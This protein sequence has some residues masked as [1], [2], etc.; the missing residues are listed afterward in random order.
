M[1]EYDNVLTPDDVL[2]LAAGKTGLSEVDSDSWREGLAI[3]LD[4]INTS[5]AYSESGRNRI[6]SDCVAAL[7]RRL[8]VHDY[9]QSHPEVLDAPVQRPLIV[10]G[11]PRTGT[12]VISY[13]L[14]QDPA[15]R[16]LVHWQCV[17]PIPPATSDMLRTD[18]RCL[19]LLEEQRRMLEMVTAANMALP[20]WEDADG[21][22]EDMF[23]HNQDFKGLSWDSYLASS[24]Y[25]EWLFHE[26]DMTSTYEYQKRYLQVLQS[27]A[28]GT[29]SLKMPSHSVHIDALLTVFPDARLIWA[30]RDPYKATGSLGNLWKLPK[31]M[32]LKPEAIDLHA[33]GRNAMAQMQFHV[34]RPLRARDRVGDDRFFHMYYSEMM[35]DPIGVMRRIYEWA[36]DDLTP[37]VEGRMRTWLADHPQDRFGPNAY[38]LDQYGLS[39]DR[40]RPVFAEYLDTFDIELEATP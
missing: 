40:L 7:G 10:L 14:D 1:S 34:E 22:T 39:V 16:S 33:M 4:E 24:R 23:I 18:P 26:T 31:G 11:M 9:I 13:L 19:A 15:R 28:P 30:H 6:I 3:I 29:W 38:S 25:A 5:P 32:T 8:Q 27:T 20:H 2:K 17:D 35:S 36:G 12:T 21:P 37:E